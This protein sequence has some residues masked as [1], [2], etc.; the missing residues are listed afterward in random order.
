[1]K[2]QKNANISHNSKCFLVRSIANV[3]DR[4]YIFK[5][6]ALEGLLNHKLSLCVSEGTIHEK[7]VSDSREM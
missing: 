1:M 6:S 3:S 4:K 5:V 2:R 7:L